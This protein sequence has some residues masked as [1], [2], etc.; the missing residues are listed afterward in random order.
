MSISRVTPTKRSGTIASG[1]QAQVLMPANAGRLKWMIRNVSTGTLWF[2][3]TGNATMDHNSF[4]LLP[5]EYFECPADGVQ[6]SA[7]SIIGATTG[8][9]F[10]AEEW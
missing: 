6:I 10:F 1:G 8:Q 5:G 4:Q 2:S 3:A 9:A 7:I